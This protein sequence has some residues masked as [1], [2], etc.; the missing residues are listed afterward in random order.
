[1][2]SIFSQIEKS[3]T[4]EIHRIMEIV[5]PLL[6]DQAPLIWQYPHITWHSAEGYAIPEL[7]K[8]LLELAST[9]EKTRV[10][11]TGIGMFTGKVQVL[12]LPVIKTPALVH[13]Q[14]Q[15]IS[16][17]K[18]ISKEASRFFQP[19]IWIPHITIISDENEQ[20]SIP[21]AIQ[22][23]SETRVDFEVEINNLALGRYTGDTAQILFEIPIKI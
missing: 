3:E 13:M 2:L 8:S 22:V 14:K 6:A 21:K 16:H 9:W 15:I 23:L 17:A 11:V 5:R 7:E 10:R 4:S 18:A 12:Y 20:Q 1:M 19:E